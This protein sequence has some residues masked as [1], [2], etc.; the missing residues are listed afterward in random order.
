[1]LVTR[2]VLNTQTL[3]SCLLDLKQHLM[4][5]FTLLR[6]ILVCQMLVTI[7]TM[8]KDVRIKEQVCKT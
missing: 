2:L 6:N 8:L 1:M 7:L 5:G 3:Y 4:Q